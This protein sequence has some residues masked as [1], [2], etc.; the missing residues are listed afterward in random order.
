M[1]GAFTASQN[2]VKSHKPT[3]LFNSIWVAFKASASSYTRKDKDF[4]ALLGKKD[5]E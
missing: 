5:T 1:Q 3:Q 2:P 4:S